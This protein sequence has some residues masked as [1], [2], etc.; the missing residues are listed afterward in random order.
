MM[1]L[2][3]CDFLSSSHKSSEAS[4]IENPLLCFLLFPSKFC[5]PPFPL[6]KCKDPVPGPP[7]PQPKYLSPCPLPLQSPPNST[8]VAQLQTCPSLGAAIPSP[9][10]LPSEMA[11]L[12]VFPFDPPMP[13]NPLPKG[14]G[15][16]KK[17]LF[18]GLCCLFSV[19]LFSLMLEKEKVREEK[20]K[21][22]QT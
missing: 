18:F 6:R 21:V 10:S 20:R 15:K 14:L 7:Q 1:L 17:T 11:Q 3:S 19:C 13:A 4:K 9:G 5:L 22:R 8:L 12:H 2:C 16:P